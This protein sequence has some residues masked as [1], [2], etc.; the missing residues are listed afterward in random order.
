TRTYVYNESANT[1]GANLPNALTGIIDENGARFATYKY[2]SSGRAISSEHDV[3]NGS[4]VTPVEKVSIVYST[5]SNG[6]VTSSAVTDALGTTRTYSF[7]NI[8][9]VV[10]NT[11][12]T[13]PCN[14]GCGASAATTYDANGNIASKTDFNGNVTNYAYDLTRN[15]ETSR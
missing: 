4:T 9:G 15:L 6:N 1:S 8:L 5:D 7:T 10:K 11:G 12:V 14:A 2:D 13:Q 3:V